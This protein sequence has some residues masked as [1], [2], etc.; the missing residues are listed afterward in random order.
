L[1]GDA[2]MIGLRLIRATAVQQ[3]RGSRVA[4]LPIRMGD[5]MRIAAGLLAAAI[6]LS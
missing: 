4:A 2:R 1:S 3:G 5:G 6:G